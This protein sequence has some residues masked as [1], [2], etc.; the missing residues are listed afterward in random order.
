MK[1]GVALAA[2][3]LAGRFRNDILPELT[4]FRANTTAMAS[5]MLEMIAEDWDRTAFNLVAE[6]RATRELLRDGAQL[7]AD[8]PLAEA[9]NGNDD[10]LHLSSLERE[11]RRLRTALIEL[12]ARIEGRD[13][14]LARDLEQAIWSEL[15]RSVEARR[16]SSANF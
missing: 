5:A 4:G 2:R 16:M 13:D 14:D 11:N 10:D 15:S 8:P 7:L 9:A 6:N 3:E 12:H 1:P